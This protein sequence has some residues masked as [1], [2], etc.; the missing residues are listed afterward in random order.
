MN[1]FGGDWTKIKIEMPGKYMNKYR[2]E[3][4]RLQNW[5]Y[6][7]NAAYFITICARNREC[8]FGDVVN[9]KIQLSPVGAIANVLWYEIR[10]HAKNVELGEFIVMPNHVHGIIILHGRR[11]RGDN[12]RDD[13]GDNAC[14]V[15]TIP[16]IPGTTIGQQRFQNQGKNTISSII[17]GY[18]SAV[19]KHCNRLGLDFGWQSR[20]Y[21]HIIR[22]D[23]SFHNISNYIID[24][25]AK[26][27]ADKLFNQSP[28]NETNAH[29]PDPRC[30]RL[31]G[32]ESL[33]QGEIQ[34]D[35]LPGKRRNCFL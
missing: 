19:T 33:V 17:G 9:G 12:R 24:N 8:F 18:K 3:S 13:R 30:S 25:P 11:D 23:Q 16:T 27:T 29:S 2:S 5:N 7:W 26:W 22:D 31:P 15:P 10:N 32:Y 4:V 14:V 20:F 21:D 28:K 35:T 6:G 34:L 1:L